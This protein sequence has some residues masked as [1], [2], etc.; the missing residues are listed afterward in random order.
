M[1]KMKYVKTVIFLCMIM[2]YLTHFIMTFL[3]RLLFLRQEL[4]S[5]FDL[6]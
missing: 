1:F 4:S 2:Y 5:K 3:K 6:Q